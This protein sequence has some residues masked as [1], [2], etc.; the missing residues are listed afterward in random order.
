MTRSTTARRAG[1]TLVAALAAVLALVAVVAVYV[2]AVGPGAGPASA[3]TSAA[4]APPVPAAA[5]APD[6][7]D[8][9]PADGT[10]RFG[11]QLAWTEDDPTSLVGRLGLQPAQYGIFLDY[12]LTAERTDQLLSAARGAQAQDGDVFLTLEPM[13]GLTSDT[14][15]AEAL[16]G[17]LRQVNAIG[18]QVYVRFAHEM[19][20]GWYPWGQQPAAYV[21]AFRVVA[22]A[23]HTDAPG[24]AMV[25]SPNY[26]G[27]FP[28][29]GGGWT[30]KPGT[31]DWSAM[32]TDGDGALTMADDMYAPFYPGDDA[33]DWVG[34]T[35]YWFG[36]TWPWGENEVPDAGRFAAQLTGTYAGGTDPTMGFAPDETAVPDFYATYATRKPMALSETGAL[37]NTDAT[38]GADELSIKSAWMDQ[39]LGLGDEFPRLKM[40][41]WFEH[42]KS[43]QEG[44]GVVDW[45]ATSNPAVLAT[46]QGVLSV[47]RY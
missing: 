14:A 22:Q 10:T 23:V 6:L 3:G 7:A 31:A 20:G 26:G 5:D 24:N 39:V 2:G 36:Y 17:V 11:V 34:L 15:A 9:E 45:R 12:P 33:V 1:V 4:D 8:L 13:D 46:L 29:D 37:Y 18:P 28:F 38:G 47:P 44:Y 40:V 16:A 35:L 25:W 19:N 27:G 32:D 43:E 42:L 41:N 30:A 21:A